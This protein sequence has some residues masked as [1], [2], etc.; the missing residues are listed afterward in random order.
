MLQ[1][2]RA[3]EESF[4]CAQVREEA[5]EYPFLHL[6]GIMGDS[7]MVE[8]ASYVITQLECH[9]GHKHARCPWHK[10]RRLRW[11]LGKNGQAESIP[12]GKHGPSEV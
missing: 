10:G 12:G 8:K 2:Q 11:V 5:A 1:P 6:S 4:S 7:V 9:Q 3:G